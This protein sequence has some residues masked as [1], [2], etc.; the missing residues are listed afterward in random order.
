M[1]GEAPL[2]VSFCVLY[3][4]YEREIE[5]IG[6][7]GSFVCFETGSVCNSLTSNL[8]HGGIAGLR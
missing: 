6:I 3:K 5:V 4:P 8:L 2:S 7:E 1:R